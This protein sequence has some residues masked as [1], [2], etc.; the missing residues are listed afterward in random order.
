MSGLSIACKLIERVGIGKLCITI[1]DSRKPGE[2]LASSVAAGLMH[3][4][5]PRGS[6]IWKGEK[7]YAST[8]ALLDTVRDY[9]SD[10]Q[11]YKSNEILI[12]PFTKV[13][14]FDMY[15]KSSLKI[16][17]WIEMIDNDEIAKLIGYH[18]I[19]D[20]VIGGAVIKNSINVNCPL[21]LESMWAYINSSS[22]ARWI[23]A[24]INK[25]DFTSLCGTNDIVIAACST[26]IARLHDINDDDKLLKKLKYVRGQNIYIKM[27]DNDKMNNIINGQYAVCKELESEPVYLCGATHEYMKDDEELLGPPNIE[28]AKLLLMDELSM[29]NKDLRNRDVIGANAGVRLTTIRTKHGKIPFIRRHQSDDHVWFVGGFGSHGLIHH[30]L[31]ADMIAT[32]VLS[33]DTLTIYPELLEYNPELIPLQV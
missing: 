25:E 16:P 23:T 11:L 26:G 33:S 27:N 32:S 20:N 13:E 7:G 31:I 15:R 14:E 3:P 18:A 10:K 21:Y 1:Y 12:R 22:D 5:N 29:L 30:A 17:H 6:L 2:A 28:V 4:L 8:K 24:D 19:A 9:S